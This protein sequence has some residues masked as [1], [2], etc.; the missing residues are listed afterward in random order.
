MKVL[1]TA[2][3]F[4]K[5]NRTRAW[6]KAAVWLTAGALLAGG[7]LPAAAVDTS[8]SY[9]FEVSVNG[10]ENA[11]VEPGE[12]VEVK[13]SLT[14][15]DDSG[16]M[17]IYAMSAV[18]RFNT[19]L[20]ELENLT[21]NTGISSTVTELSGSLEG[22]SD[23][24]LN[25]LAPSMDGSE[26]ENGI[27]LVTLT[28]KAARYGSSLIQMRRG[29]VSTYS[30]MDSFSSALGSAVVSV[31]TAPADE[32]PA[33]PTTPTEPGDTTTPTTP[34][35]PGGTTTPSTPTEPGGTTTPTE[36]GGTTTPTTPTEPGGATT[37]IEPTTPTE[38]GGTTTP[39]EP[40]GATTPTTP[41]IPTTSGGTTTPS[42][43]TTPGG[44]A[45]PTEPDDT[46]E[47]PTPVQ[48]GEP[49][50]PANPEA[51]VTPPAPSEPGSTGQSFTDVAADAWYANA[52]Q[53]VVS[54]AYFNG[55]SADTFSPDRTM[56]RAMFVTVLG[57]MDG[58]DVSQYPNTPFADVP[59]GQWYTAYVEWA[60]ENGIVLGYGSETF[61]PD[62]PV[63]REQMAAILYRYA[64]F[65]GRDLGGADASRFRGFRD[66]DQV[67][68]YAETPMI[69][70]TDQHL[71]NGMGDATLA[72]QETAT[73]AEVAQLIRNFEQ[74]IE[75]TVHDLQWQ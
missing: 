29:S 47:P 59:A 33:A 46:I 75:A 22:W 40:G 30:G 38:P 4:M 39:T 43:P 63:T 56:T 24:T 18:L 37:P 45:T 44:A 26:W 25:Y 12:T 67:A 9:A 50:N 35:E 51:P 72:P 16:P 70:A 11:A 74:W 21:A 61:G 73:R 6:R 49:V 34:T 36:P 48:P 65:T 71:I 54:K 2:T 19:N 42:T 58:V 28:L 20:M 14:R 53:Y 60:S 41:S 32:D 68:E 31:Q 10:E 62:D 3:R 27:T 66:A 5:R 1:Q 55:T 8:R 69:W 13:L 57:R 64:Q 15:T 7:V 23:V 17:T 52:V